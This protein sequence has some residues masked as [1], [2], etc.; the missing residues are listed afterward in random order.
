MVY[1][2]RGS[3]GTE[4]DRWPLYNGRKPVPVSLSSFKHGDQ[5]LQTASRSVQTPDDQ[6]SEM[7]LDRFLILR[8]KKEKFT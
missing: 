5:A 3:S 2:R 1:G 4:G 8:V 6:T 7:F